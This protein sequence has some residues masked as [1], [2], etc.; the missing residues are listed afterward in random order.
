[1]KN[2]WEEVKLGDVC[3]LENG[4]RGKNYPGRK[5]FVETGVPFINAGHLNEDGIDMNNMNFIPKERFDLL[6][7]G[8]IRDG[9]LLFC[10][11]GSLGK[12]ALVDELNEGAI[13]SSLV[14]V[15]PKERLDKY[16]LAAY[17]GSNICAGMIDKYSNGA[18]QPNLSAKSLTCFDISLPPLPEQKRIVAILDEAFEGIDRAVANAEKNSKSIKELYLSKKNSVFDRIEQEEQTVPIESVCAEIF[19]GGDAPK[20]NFSKEKTDQYSTPII[21]NAV[22]DNGLYGYTD[23]SRVTKPSVTVAARG[24]GTGHTEIRNKPFYPIVR[25]IVLTPDTE[26]MNV[27]FLMYAIHNLK[28]L[29]SGSAIPQLTVPMIKGYSVPIPNM[30]TQEKIVQTLDNLSTEIHRLN[31]IYQRKLTSLAELKQSLLQK[32][33]SGELTANDTAINKEAVA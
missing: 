27:D 32:A 20:D 29:R 33:F 10:L 6:S 19:A 26:K 14:I 2:G 22:K 12:Y 13:A 28:I 24:S 18:A 8:K 21:A 4:D 15:R 11:R 16:F 3:V 9:D 5:A 31:S 1:M 7:N 25:L 17:F 23:L 30:Q